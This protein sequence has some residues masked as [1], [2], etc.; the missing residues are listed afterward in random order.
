MLRRVVLKLMMLSL[1]VVLWA[2]NTYGSDVSPGDLYQ[3]SI[4]ELMEIEVTS[5]SK[6]PER[7]SEAAAAV[8]VLTAEDI[9]RSGFTSI[10]EALRMVPGLEVARIDASKWSV[11]CRGFGGRLA[12]KLLVLIDGRSV[13][14]PLFSGV[15]WN[16]HDLVLEDISRIEVIRGPGATLWGANAVNGVI[17]IITKSADETCFASGSVGGGSEERVFGSVRYGARVG[18]ATCYRVY[19][20]YLDRDDYAYPSGERAADG[21]D[22]LRGGFR[23]DS[24]LDGGDHLT[25]QGDIHDSKLGETYTRV[26]YSGPPYIEVVE[27]QADVWGANLLS[28]WTH[29]VGGSSEM[30]VQLYVDRATHQSGFVA[31]TDNTLDVAYEHQQAISSGQELIWGLGYRHIDSQTEATPSTWFDPEDR[32]LDLISTFVQDNIDL[33]AD[34]WRLTVGSKFEHNDY[35]GFEVQPNIRLLWTPDDRHTSWAAVSRA[36]R[37]PSRAERDVALA[38]AVIPPGVVFPD[39]LVMLGI[40]EGN[41]DFES[42]ELVA[43]EFGYRIRPANAVSFDLALFRNQYDN[44]L[45]I[46]QGTPY[47]EQLPEAHYVLPMPEANKM[48]GYTY[49]FE[50][51]SDWQ[52]L[53][54]WRLRAAYTYLRMQITPDNTSTDT[55]TGAAGGETPRHQLWLH[56]RMD[57]PRK[58]EIDLG[59]RYVDALPSLGLDSYSTLDARVG[60]NCLG[61]VG[62]S[63]V[64]QNLLEGEHMETQALYLDSVPTEIERGV[65]AMIRWRN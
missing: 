53:K 13:Y 28:R 56:S 65:Y 47:L 46:E 33:A 21:W 34:R 44:L 4:D 60:W 32:R 49:G 63:V 52:L 48:S 14:T 22:D 37:T 29:H 35:T 43:Y 41:K 38:G 17:N 64:G 9:R 57:L 24:G 42:E 19:G 11:T 10:A 26:D 50:L 15:F 51:A 36:V 40:I 30:A 12:S 8:Y 3:L 31:H 20:K 25:I 23:M 62:I 16:R 54:Y 61:P 45:T 59:F 2:G 39:T 7:L 5:V 55:I 27:N 58:V 6:K 18:A 1:A